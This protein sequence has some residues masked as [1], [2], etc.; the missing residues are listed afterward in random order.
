[1]RLYCYFGAFDF[2]NADKFN[3]LTYLEKGAEKRCTKC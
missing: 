3:F 1:M 2:Y